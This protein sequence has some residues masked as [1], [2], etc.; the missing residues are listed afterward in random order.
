[1]QKPMEWKVRIS[2]F[3]MYEDVLGTKRKTAFW[4]L[5][6]HGRKGFFPEEPVNTDREYE[7]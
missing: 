1:L 2:G 4:R 6:D 3:V 7:D 5:Y